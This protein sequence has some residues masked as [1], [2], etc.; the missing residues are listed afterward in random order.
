MALVLGYNAKLY[1]NTGSYGSP[2]WDECPGV[3]DLTLNGERDKVD[4]STRGGGGF[5]EYVPGLA[6]HSVSFNM[7]WDNADSDLTT[8]RTAFSSA[9]ANSLEFLVLEGGSATSGNQGLR[10][11]MGV[12]GFTRNEPLDGALTVDVELAPIK[13]GDAAPAWYTVAP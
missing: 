11:K 7:N 3:K 2:T 4:V 9:T 8:I 12:F 6:D 13:N 1:R 10:A 5:R